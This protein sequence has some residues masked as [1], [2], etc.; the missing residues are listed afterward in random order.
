M[1][2]EKT[3]KDIGYPA[4][5]DVVIKKINGIHISNFRTLKNRYIPLGENVTL[6]SGK[7][8]TM[9]TSILGL[10]AHPFSS[11]NSAK[12]LFGE[13]LKTQHKN[14]FK[15][16]LDKDVKDYK[17]YLHLNTIKNEEI[18]EPIRM[19]K[20]GNR[21]RVT[22]GKDNTKGLGNFYLNTSYVNFKRLYPMLETNAKESTGEHF[23]KKEMIDFI[24]DGQ[25]KIMNKN[26]YGKA[27]PVSEVKGRVKSTFGPSGEYYD[28]V[29][30]SSGEDNLGHILTKMYAF[31]TNKYNDDKDQLQ[32]IF[33]I[34]EIEAG[35]HPVAQEKF[36][37][38][39]FSWSKKHNIQVVATTH[40]LYLIQYALRKRL[41]NEHISKRIQVN[42]LSTAFVEER[43]YS[44]IKNPDYKQA[45]KE[46]TFKTISDLNDGYKINVLCEDKVAEYYIKRIVKK[47]E[48]NNRINYLSGITNQEGVKGNSWKS[49]KSLI[50]NGAELLKDSIVVFDADVPRKINSKKVEILWLPSMDVLPVEKEI[51]KFIF[52]IKDN[53]EFFKKFDKEKQAFLSEFYS[54]NLTNLDKMEDVRDIPTDKF[55]KWADNDSNF[56]KYVTYYVSRNFD[57]V[58]DFRICFIQ[59][60]NRIL[61]SKS[62]PTFEIDK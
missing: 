51:V 13:D 15:L 62:L 10:I 11:K 2:D 6:L 60:L 61:E 55:K 52:E 47:T 48:I 44:V 31:M 20:R 17:Y 14:V 23:P 21:H 19:Y 30:M 1:F 45:Y 12:D 7:N 40:S 27:V 56:K 50:T 46:L 29:S 3:A 57:Y 34:D 37:D 32:G 4:I 18:Y 9:K 5:K 41:E 38:F 16:S 35:L 28:F 33:C 24:N 53:D 36:F 26:E 54:Y 39:I 25:R 49:L 59:S 43:N 42:M 8:G 22:V 58:K